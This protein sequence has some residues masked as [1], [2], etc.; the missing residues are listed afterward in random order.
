MK[1]KFALLILMI[2]ALSV[3]LVACNN[4]DPTEIATRWQPD[5]YTFN[6]T[7]ADFTTG[8][9]YLSNDEIYSNLDQIAPDDVSGTYTL[10]IEQTS[11]TTNWTVTTSQTLYAQYS[12]SNVTLSDSELQQVIVT[13]A[14][15]ISGTTLTPEDN[16]VI[17]KSTTYTEVVFDDS[18]KQTPLSSKTELNG[19]YIGRRHQEVSSYTVETTYDYSGKRAVAKISIDGNDP[20]KHKFGRNASFIDSNQI[21]MYVRSLDKPSKGFQDNP[22]VTVFNPY[23]GET[24]SVTFTLNYDTQLLLTDT[25]RNATVK[26]SVNVVTVK[27]GGTHFMQQENV[28]NLTKTAG[29]EDVDLLRGDRKDADKPKY[30]TIRFR[31]GYLAYELKTYDENIWNALQPAAAPEA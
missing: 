9:E 19:F 27:V 20:V 3:A 12:K 5:E 15:E 25:L 16:K 29:F 26:T 2:L 28:P 22:S 21:L 4:A 18:K 6:I 23:T 24:S 13:D 31:V 11:G 7:K 8:Q 1:R 17:L 10:K 30:T 14:Q